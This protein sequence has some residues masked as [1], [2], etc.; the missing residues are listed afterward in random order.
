MRIRPAMLFAAILSLTACPAFA[1]AVGPDVITGDIA[2]G[3]DITRFATADGVTS[4]A[5]GTTSCNIGTS[6]AVWYSGSNLHPVIGQNMFRLKNGRFEQIG[7][8]WVKHGFATE[9]EQLCGSCIPTDGTTLGVGCSDTYFAVLNGVQARLGPK[10]QVNASTGYFPY[11][12][13]APPAQPGIGRRLQV[14]NNDLESSLNPGALYF[15]E[16]QY[17]TPD[18][19]FFGNAANNC[20][21]RQIELTPTSPYLATPVGGTHQRVPAIFAW[22]ASD[23]LV[24][25][26]SMVVE[27]DGGAG[28]NGLFWAA[29]RAAF[30]GGC[31]WHYEYAVQNINSHQS[32]GSFSVPLP[33]GIVPTNIGFH[34]VDYHSGEPF[35]GADWSATVANDSITWSTESFAQNANANA[36][37]WGTLYNFR[38]DIDA[39]PTC[40][41]SVTLGLFRTA[42]VFVST[43]MVT[44]RAGSGCFK[45]GDLDGDCDVDGEDLWYFLAAYG[46]CQ[47]DPAFA[48]EADMNDDNCVDLVDYQ[49]WLTRYRE[50]VN[51]ALAEPPDPH[52]SPGKP[53]DLNHD[54]QA[55]QADLQ[56]LI[57]V[58]LGMDA[59]PD[60]VQRADLDGSG[61]VNAKDIQPF[62]AALSSGS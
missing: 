27:N 29:G 60:H 51:N 33:P 20:S 37:R 43:Y 30:L 7:Q 54:G 9:N 40:D 49:L 23:Q 25:L 42:G 6:E 61:Q 47:S 45:S 4:Y 13:T 15:I 41:G 1:P 53:G 28:Y 58:M 5:F 31:T 44:P 59:N 32:G 11:P 16:G 12:F 14:H 21:W 17:V 8:A 62:I 2:G 24:Q 39:P 48:G 19:S 36:L 35:N 22:N 55:N 26:S 56:I 3:D 18:D 34:D 38:F 57:D 52:A 10:S 46:A 50:Y